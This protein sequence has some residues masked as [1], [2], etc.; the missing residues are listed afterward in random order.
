[1]LS[2]RCKNRG[3][4]LVELL[5]VLA[6]ITMLVGL[7]VPSLSMV[8]KIAKET[9]QRAQLASI[10]GAL[11]TFR[12]DYGDYPPSAYEEPGPLQGY[13]GGQKL[14][15][16]LLGWDL[17]GFHPQTMWD[18]LGIAYQP[19]RPSLANLNAR[20]GR[21]LEMEAANA[22]R[23][24]T[25]EGLFK[26]TGPLAK[27]TFVL[28]DVFGTVGKVTIGGKTFKAGAPV[29]YYRADTSSKRMNSDVIEGRI[30]D[31]EDNIHI[32]VAKAVKDGGADHPLNQTDLDFFYEVYIRDPKVPGQ[33]PYRPDSY[34]LITAGADGI[35]GTGDDICNF[36]N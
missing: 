7:L 10:E 32:I 13:G 23:V 16:A 28:C 9:K 21:Y 12:N 6:V 31:H 25:P 18:G 5:T 27:H 35:Y 14:A 11:T 26:N 22:F 17:M 2:V 34:L 33:W 20:K 3:F 30:Y 29:L 15:E 19:P 4:T 8:R 36:G 1:M 24:D